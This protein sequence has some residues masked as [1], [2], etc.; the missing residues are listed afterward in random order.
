MTQFKE[1]AKAQ[2]IELPAVLTN[3]DPETGLPAFAKAKADDFQQYI[4]KAAEEAKPPDFK[5][6]EI[7][8]AAAAAEFAVKSTQ[9]EIHSST[10][11]LQT[12]D[13]ILTANAE[14]QAMICAETVESSTQ[15]E[16]AIFVEMATQV[17]G[18]DTAESE[19]Q[20]EL[21]CVEADIQVSIRPIT[22]D[23]E[24]EMLIDY[25]ESTTQIEF[26]SKETATRSAVVHNDMESQVDAVE[27]S[28]NHS[29]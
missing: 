9:Y 22:V 19:T 12:A 3:L 29:T 18:A 24:T 17:N 20:V 2:G 27:F 7:Q 25:A 15:V 13:L 14:L 8:T 5:S 6:I 11:Q 28:D 16:H 10:V 23:S 21:V 4:E 1:K 26:D